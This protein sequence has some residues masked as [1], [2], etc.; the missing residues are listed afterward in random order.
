MTR[1]IILVILLFIVCTESHGQSSWTVC[2]RPSPPVL[3]RGD[4]L[5]A[6][7]TQ[8]IHREENEILVRLGYID[9][10]AATIQEIRDNLEVGLLVSNNKYNV[11]GFTMLYSPKGH[12]GIG[13][14]HM[15]GNRTL[16]SLLEKL[17]MYTIKRGDKIEFENIRIQKAGNNNSVPVKAIKITA[18]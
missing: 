15:T 16:P 17:K 14:Y 12:D 3:I 7:L 2:P 6:F 11:I 18:L 1:L 5:H 10:N 13:P 9:S 8:H 4:S